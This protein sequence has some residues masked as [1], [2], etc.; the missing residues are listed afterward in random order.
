MS[1]DITCTSTYRMSNKQYYFDPAMMKARIRDKMVKDLANFLYDEKL[2]L[3]THDNCVEFRLDI[4]A[5]SPDK[6]WELVNK[7]AEEIAFRFK[8]PVVCEYDNTKVPR[9]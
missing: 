1:E 6:F 9:T 5:A 7:K 4:C 2:E 3:V 8:E